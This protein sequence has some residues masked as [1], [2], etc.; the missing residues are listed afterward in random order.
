MTGG[1][2]KPADVL[3]TRD[4]IPEAVR[5]GDVYFS[6]EGGL[7]EARYVFLR[8]N[9]LPDRFRGCTRFTIGE[10]GFGTGLNFLAAWQSFL[11][12]APP[13]AV[14]H[15]FS[16]EKHP[17][18]AADLARAH[19]NWPELAEA[20]AELRRATP[21]PVPGIHRL[22]LGEGRVR[23]TLLYGDART[24]LP[25]VDARADAW[26]LDGFAPARNPE[27]W[28]DAVLAELPRLSAPGASVATFTAAGG[29]RRALSAAGFRMEKVTGFGRKR[30]MLRG[31][32]AEISP[33]GSKIASPASVIIVGAGAAGCA[34]AHALALRGVSV[35][36]I[37]RRKDAG[38]ETSANAAAIL[39][40][41]SSRVWM[42][43]TR[44]YLSALSFARRQV[45]G[46]RLAGH[47]V[48]GEF[49]GMV[50]C[51]KPS[52]EAGRLLEIPAL[53]GLDAEVVQ[54]GDAAEVSRITGLEVTTGGLFWPQSGWYSLADYCRACLSHPRITLRCNTEITAITQTG[55]GWA[56]WAGEKRIAEASALV[57]A[58]AQEALKLAP[59]LAL[60]LAALRG[61]VTMVSETPATSML[62]TVLCFG[63][64]L[65]PAHQG[66]HH[67]GATYERH[68]HDTGVYE[69]GHRANLALLA[70]ILRPP[71]PEV[72]GGWA[73]IRATT[74]D[75]LPIAGET[76][77]PGL[78][79]TLGHGSRGALSCPLAGELLAS[80]VTGETAPLERD[81]RHALSPQRFRS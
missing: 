9:G 55:G 19:E 69:D 75:K 79:V 8:H 46:L 48:A 39:F 77:L 49:C 81:L 44:F 32:L 38:A 27:M 34:A 62:K 52:Q 17:L 58:A 47:A 21:A 64:Y 66:R 33:V 57:L 7:E 23:L 68:R 37:D 11:S 18:R 3:W 67:L 56:A 41:F 65:T 63:G 50:Q 20:A 80:A 10:T 6:R 78:Y 26:F 35:T 60:P 25:A 54:A 29:V 61:Q 72:S 31:R 24:L 42:K 28:Q 45:E 40:P 12:H 13:S 59:G 22:L 14:L 71:L 16:V 2:V 43:Q 53:L 70:S 5:Y 76:D 51:P 4:G 36:L 15:Y 30:E 73:G 74:P 1:G